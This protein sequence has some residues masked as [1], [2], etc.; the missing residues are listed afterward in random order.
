LGRAA[1]VCVASSVGPGRMSRFADVPLGA[2]LR[3]ETSAHVRYAMGDELDTDVYDYDT[4]GNNGCPLLVLT[5]VDKS[6]R[7][8]PG[9]RGRT[10]LCL[11]LPTGISGGIG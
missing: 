9:G 7:M 5:P 2:V 10:L 4:G 6:C 3:V 8:F 11:T 1:S